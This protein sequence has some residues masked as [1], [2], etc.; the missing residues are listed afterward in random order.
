MVHK[1]ATLPFPVLTNDT[2][3]SSVQTA[4][5][6]L[7]KQTTLENNSLDRFVKA[8]SMLKTFNESNSKVPVV[9]FAFSVLDKVAQGNFTKWS[10]VYDISHKE[11]HFKTADN[12]DIKIVRFATFDLGCSHPARMFNM[13]QDGKGDVSK[14]F[15]LS[16][17]KI[18][19]IVLHQAIMESSSRFTISAKREDEMLNYEESITCRKQGP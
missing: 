10:I 8:C 3:T 12:K 6:M 19:Q 2:Y 9:D 15:V 14:S 5:A 7:G 18:R 16:D 4:T 13:N 17:K 11:I 1:D